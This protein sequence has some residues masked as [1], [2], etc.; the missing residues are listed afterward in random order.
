MVVPEVRPKTTPG[1]APKGQLT[2]VAIIA[3][4][5]VVV[6]VAAAVVRPMLRSSTPPAAA[7]QGSAPAK[8]GG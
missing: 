5:V 3:L 7:I 1:K 6:G 8:A 4:I 2:Y